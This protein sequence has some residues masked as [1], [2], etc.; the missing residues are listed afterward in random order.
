MSANEASSIPDRSYGCS[1]GCGN[2][3]D[4]IVIDVASGTTE[5]L[6][7]PDYCRLAAD[8]LKAVMEPDSEEVRQAVAAMGQIDAVPMNGSKVKARGKNAPTNADDPDLIAAFDGIITAD[9]L[10]D[11]FR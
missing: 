3:Y 2:P 11:E 4:Y 1:F 5:F 8:M 10:P 9:E 6:C 7:L